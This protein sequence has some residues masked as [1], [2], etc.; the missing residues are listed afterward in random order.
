M[1]VEEKILERIQTLIF[2]GNK[3]RRGSNL[4]NFSRGS[5]TEESIGWLVSVQNLVQ[6][7][8]PDSNHPYR[9]MTDKLVELGF[10][11]SL[12]S[13]ITDTVGNLNE[14]L[15][16]FSVDI[17]K[18]LLSSMLDAAR[19]ETFDDFLDHAQDY[20]NRNLKQE[21]GVIAGVVFEDTIRRICEKHQIVQKSISLEDLINALVKNVVI[22]QLKA[23]RAKA[24]SHVRTKAT[25]AQW[26]EFELEDVKATIEFTRELILSNLDS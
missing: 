16:Q 1:P 6:I 11:Q 10:E 5:N 23:K 4:T 17:K 21:A 15:E 2:N 26:D 3:L 18:G 14:L 25:H 8:C 13:P 24:S 9:K 19:G 7:V 12:K 20:L 22:S